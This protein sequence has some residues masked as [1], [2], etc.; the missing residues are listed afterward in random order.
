MKIINGVSGPSVFYLDC[1]ISTSL[2]LLCF[3]ASSFLLL[4]SFLMSPSPPF[5]LLSLTLALAF[6]LSI[7]Q[8]SGMDDGV[9]CCLATVVAM[10]T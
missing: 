7:C 6:S 5:S 10:G 9:V 2:L 4:H 3:H 1:I 8:T